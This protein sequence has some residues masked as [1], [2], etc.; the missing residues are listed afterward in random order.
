MHAVAAISQSAL[1]HNLSIVRAQ[2]PHCKIVSM[3]KANAYG[4]H[5]SH[6]TP[7]LQADLLGVSELSEARQLR[8]LCN[9]PILLLPG[10][11]NPTDLNEAI[12]LGCH[13]VIHH[14]SQVALIANATQ[15]LNI[16]LKVDTGMHRL[17]LSADE[18]NSSIQQLVKNP[19]IHIEAVMSHFACADEP[20]NVK[21][22][23]QIS[24][25]N[26]LDIACFNRSMA[27]SAAILSQ[28]SVHFDYVRPGIMLYGV[29]PFGEPDETLQPVMQLS[30]PVVS[31]K[32]ISVGECVGYGA[33]WQAKEDTTIAVIGIGYG[34]G[35]P[36]HAK[37]G[38]PVLINNTLYP[39]AGR[40]SMDLICVD[41]G[42]ALVNIGD[43]AILWGHDKLRVET[44]AQYSD[45]IGYE[46]LTHVSS[47]VNF[48]KT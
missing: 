17:G 2:A 8:Q 35:Y 22:L 23:Q 27:N 33:T 7:L 37:N 38:T 11:Y 20:S 46:L 12:E 30:A 18:L 47:R 40:V 15:A 36:R 9:Q 6:S 48:I 1:A 13:V 14:P 39:L 29:S 42:N 45:T 43:K 4:H 21:N 24:H 41:I 16:W 25:F 5:L 34:D 3:V 31:I 26:Q 10:V 44:I 28:P 32:K 19:N